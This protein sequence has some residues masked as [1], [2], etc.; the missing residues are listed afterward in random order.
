MPEYLAPGVYVEEID[1][2]SKPIEGVSTSTA[3][4]IGV[5]E[6]GPVN[7]PILLTSLGDYTRWFGE[8]L[9][10]TRFPGPLLHAARCRGLLHQRRQASVS[11]AHS[12]H[13]RRNLRRRGVVRPR[14]ADRRGHHDPPLGRRAQR[15]AR[16]RTACVRARYLGPQ[17]RRFDP[18]RRRQPVGVPS[19][20]RGSGRD[21]QQARAAVV[22]A[23]DL[24]R[25]R[26]PRWKSSRRL[27]MQPIQ[28]RLRLPSPPRPATLLSKS[29]APP[30]ISPLW[31]ALYRSLSK[32]EA[33]QPASI[34][35]P[36]L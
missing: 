34:A 19:G 18:H 30:L 31:Q 24:A 6:R 2:G 7:V 8:R 11:H 28:G 3:G 27:P 12:R 20:R 5:T 15:Y 23:V 17:C 4:M 14:H 29:A 1:T 33:R 32:S 21:Q 25:R 35:I 36:A 9:S 16:S 13:R 22:P 26:R 10:F